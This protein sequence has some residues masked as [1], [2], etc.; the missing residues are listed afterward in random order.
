MRGVVRWLHEP[1]N[2]KP[3]ACAYIFGSELIGSK[4]YGTVGTSSNL[5]SNGVLVDGLL[6]PTI[7]LIVRIL[8]LGIEGFLRRDLS[9]RRRSRFHPFLYGPSLRDAE[10][11]S[12]CD[13]SWGFGNEIRRA[14]QT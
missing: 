14:V 4:M 11:A 6:R 13:A 3:A 12:A 2:P 7:C 9:S 5:L 10:T 8:G 1:M